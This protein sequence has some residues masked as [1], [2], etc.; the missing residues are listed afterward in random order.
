MNN[1]SIT[2]LRLSDEGRS[3]LPHLDIHPTA[4][5]AVKYLSM[6]R[7]SPHQIFSNLALLELLMWSIEVRI[8][9]NAH[10]MMLSLNIPPLDDAGI[11]RP[12]K[13][14]NACPP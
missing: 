1:R 2:T 12:N 8:I 10:P 14:P 9:N 6:N 7:Y 5:A 4:A 11:I 3:V 13:P